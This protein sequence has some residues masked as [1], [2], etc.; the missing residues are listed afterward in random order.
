MISKR[1]AKIYISGHGTKADGRNAFTFVHIYSN[2]TIYFSL[3]LG[4][5]FSF[6]FLRI[7]LF[8]MGCKSCGGF[9]LL[10]F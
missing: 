1:Q 10:N 8:K 6:I 2:E 7:E 9:V 5:F 3:Y 4:F